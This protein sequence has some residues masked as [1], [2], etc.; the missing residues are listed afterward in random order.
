MEWLMLPLAAVVAAAAVVARDLWREHPHRHAVTA[1]QDRRLA[2]ERAVRA[3]EAD[4]GA[5]REAAERLSLE[6]RLRG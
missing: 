3:V 6:Q 5:A 2:E 1:G 4:R